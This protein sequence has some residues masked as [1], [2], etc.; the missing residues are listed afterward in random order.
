[1]MNI[2]STMYNYVMTM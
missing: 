2:T 1:M